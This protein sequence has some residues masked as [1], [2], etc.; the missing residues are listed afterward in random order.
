MKI[1][2]QKKNGNPGFGIDFFW[3]L[4]IQTKRP[5]T[6]ADLFIPE[7]FYDYFYIHTG[8]IECHDPSQ[9]DTFT[10]PFQSLKTLYTRPLTFAIST[11]A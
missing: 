6:L 3:M 9:G 2:F 1:T 7:L 4:E 10:V 5:S 8:T 11:P